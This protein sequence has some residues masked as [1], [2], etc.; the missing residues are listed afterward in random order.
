MKGKGR[1]GETV[2]D[3]ANR[4][5]GVITEAKWF[6]DVRRWEYSYEEL[7][8]HRPLWGWL[9]GSDLVMPGVIPVMDEREEV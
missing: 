7:W 6:K 8:T 3:V 4:Q 9:R 1:I 2:Y 5:W